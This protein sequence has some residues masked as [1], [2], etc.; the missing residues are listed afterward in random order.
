MLHFD[1]SVMV[2]DS[3]PVQDN[4]NWLDFTHALT[5]ANAGRV[6][7]ERWPEVLPD[8][9]LQ[10]ACFTG[11]NVKYTDETQ[12]VSRWSVDNPIAFFEQASR[13]VFDHGQFEYIV[14][15]HLV[16]MISACREEVLARPDAPWAG[17]MA[18]S[19]NRFLNE[20]LK[21]KHTTRTARQALGFVAAEG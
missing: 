1:L 16:K 2:A 14:S 9:L 7:A 21:R 19:V 10:I 20:P 18:A 17:V 12:D 15:I 6:Q 4:I 11:R 3:R 5:F 8:V 13:E